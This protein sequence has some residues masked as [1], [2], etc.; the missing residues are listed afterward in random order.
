[1]SFLRKYVPQL[2]QELQSDI[3]EGN[4]SQ[5][6]LDICLQMRKKGK[7]L[8]T[9]E[10]ELEH[11]SNHTHFIADKVAVNNA[12]NYTYVILKNFNFLQK[13]IFISYVLLIGN[14]NVYGLAKL[15]QE[16]LG[17]RRL[18]AFKTYTLNLL[19]I[20]KGIKSYLVTSVS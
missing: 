14:A 18:S 3:R 10:I 4:G 12:R 7:F 16:L 5:W 19:G 15:F 20:F 2:D 17:R 6:E 9:P 1:M 8:F 13:L 11:D